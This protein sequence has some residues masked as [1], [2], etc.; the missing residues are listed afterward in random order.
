MHFL[1][2]NFSLGNTQ[3][4]ENIIIHLNYE[5]GTFSRLLKMVECNKIRKWLAEMSAWKLI[6]VS[7]PVYRWNTTN[8][9]FF[10]DFYFIHFITLFWFAEEAAQ[11]LASTVTVD[12]TNYSISFNEFLQFMSQQQNG[13]PDEETL[14]DVFA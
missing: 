8:V 10:H 3:T 1:Q 14:V 12:T 13:E 2:F 4:R 5:K 11:A 9:R 7:F 6:S